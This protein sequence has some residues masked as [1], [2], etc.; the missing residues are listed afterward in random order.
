[1]A[2]SF[3]DIS[4]ALDTRLNLLSTANSVPVAWENKL[5]TPANGAVYMRQ[6]LLPNSAE[7]L[8]VSNSS[9][10]EHL[11]IYQVDVM[12]PIE[13]GKAV[14]INLADDIADQF[15]RGTI[16]TYNGVN[17]VVRNVSRNGGR[18]DGS[19]FIIAVSVSYRSIVSSR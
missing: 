11:G 5:F 10:D 12:S 16:L 1:M 17:V 8:T 6:T 7:G 18:R 3:L 13:G 19:W 4:G 14:A 9:D 2:T 15:K